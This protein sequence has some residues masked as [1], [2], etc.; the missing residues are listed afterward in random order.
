MVVPGQVELRPQRIAG[1]LGILAPL[2]AKQAAQRLSE[3]TA[4]TDDYL[5]LARARLVRIGLGRVALQPV[6]VGE[7]RI[8]RQDAGRRVVEQHAEAPKKEIVG[9]GREIGRDARIVHLPTPTGP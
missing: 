1:V 8:Q 9:L 6:E 7:E 4:D 3:V 2:A 5:L